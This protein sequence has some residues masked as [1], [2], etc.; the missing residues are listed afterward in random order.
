MDRSMTALKRPVLL[1]VGDL[2][3]PA[4]EHMIW[5]FGCS[6]G[7]FL[8]DLPAGRLRSQLAI[9]PGGLPRHH[10]APDRGSFRTRS[11]NS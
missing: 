8:S 6:A 7:T 2:D 10:A 4:A 3:L 9:Q 5:L 1:I 11:G